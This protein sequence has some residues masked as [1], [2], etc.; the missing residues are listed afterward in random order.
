M[1]VEQHKRAC[2]ARFMSAVRNG[3]SSDYAGGQAIVQRVREAHGDKAAE[4]AR[5]ELFNYIRSEKRIN[6]TTAESSSKKSTENAPRTV[7]GS[8]GSVRIG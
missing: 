1:D 2:L 5:L 7:K 4:T 8:R 6:A 3:R